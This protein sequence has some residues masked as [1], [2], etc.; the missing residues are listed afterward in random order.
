MLRALMSVK[1]PTAVPSL[2][3]TLAISPYHMLNVT[4]PPQFL[5]IL[6]CPLIK[7]SRKIPAACSPTFFCPVLACKKL[8]GGA[9]EQDSVATANV[10]R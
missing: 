4:D 1:N 10:T 2:K 9:Y 6:I 5:E 3:L 8:G 7:F